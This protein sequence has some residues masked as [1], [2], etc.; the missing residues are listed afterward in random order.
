[1]KISEILKQFK[2][3][4]PDAEYAEKSKR[5]VLAAPQS[6]A[7][8][9][10]GIMI[11]LRFLETGAALALGGFF[12][13]LATGSFSGSKYLAPV[14]YSVIDPNGL[15]AEAQAIDIQIQ[16]ANLDYAVASTSESTTATVTG[17]A[18]AMVRAL[19]VKGS[20]TAVSSA[21]STASASTTVPSTLSV[22][23]SLKALS[24]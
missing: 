13:L 19:T 17:N 18:K 21:T 1:M 9:D 20:G 15:H 16:L 22:D 2:T 7:V 11:F 24:Q 14:Q 12:I 8:R 5:A 23:E 4:T 3:I 6:F 10:R